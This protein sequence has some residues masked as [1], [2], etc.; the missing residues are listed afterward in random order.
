MSHEIKDARRRLLVA[1]LAME[2]MRAWVCVL[3]DDDM[4]ASASA[5]L[6]LVAAL[7]VGQAEGRP[8][9]P[10]KAAQYAGL[11]RPTA[12]RRIANLQR[13]GIIVRLGKN[14]FV[15]DLD[16]VNSPRVVENAIASQQHVK[17]AAAD[18]LKMDGLAIASND[19]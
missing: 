8:M 7:F 6:M 3:L 19:K 14:R 4:T 5:D 15:I 18:L 16:L 11:P 12:A 13:R 17:R 10:T 9:N 1:R 2:L